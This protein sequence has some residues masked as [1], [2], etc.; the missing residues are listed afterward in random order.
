MPRN[1]YAQSWRDLHIAGARRVWSWREFVA[2][3][4]LFLALVLSFILSV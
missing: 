1:K 3:A 2:L 4:A